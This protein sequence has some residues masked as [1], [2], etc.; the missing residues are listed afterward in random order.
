MLQSSKQGFAKES[1]DWWCREYN[2]KAKFA[3][4]HWQMHVA[5][6]RCSTG[7]CGGKNGK[8]RKWIRG[9]TNEG[10]EGRVRIKGSGRQSGTGSSSFVLLGERLACRNSRLPVWRSQSQSESQSQ[11]QKKLSQKSSRSVIG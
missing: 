8:D 9:E 10:V 5:R 7:A 4:L 3:L 1:K 6:D 11:S 2:L